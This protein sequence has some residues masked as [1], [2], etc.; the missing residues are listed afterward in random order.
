MTNSKCILLA[1]LCSLCFSVRVEAD[2]YSPFKFE[3]LQ[4]L[5]QSADTVVTATIE[6]VTVGQRGDIYTD[7]TDTQVRCLVRE[8]YL[9]E[10]KLKRKSI[11]VVFGAGDQ[12]MNTP[13]QGPMLLILKKENDRYRLC[14]FETY[15]A[16]RLDS[17][18]TVKIW[19]E[20]KKG[21]LYS[22][23]EIV[24][25]IKT[26]SKSRVEMTTQL[27]NNLS[28]SDGY[29]P[30]RF[31]FRNTGETAVL[32]L[33]P[34]YCFN[35]LQSKRIIIGRRDLESLTWW[36]VDHWEFLRELEPLLKLEPGS[37]RSY[38]YRIPFE[39]LHVDAVG[40]Y[41]V[42]FDY[43]PYQLSTW[44]DKAKI[45]DQQMRRV[46]LGVPRTTRQIVSIKKAAQV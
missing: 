8:V 46:W 2:T 27:A 4:G 5:T 6:S 41:Q 9:G 11:M 24:A 7:T 16:L 14:F 40:D 33:P 34:S 12:P 15:G 28:L 38:S 10:K 22:L 45:T 1:V 44:S 17:D 3:V 39:V 21:P 43:H 42:T 30:V 23:K 31:T 37:E 26:Y 29:L 36:S 35:S 18:N 25:R 32:L 20:G 13:S 19:F